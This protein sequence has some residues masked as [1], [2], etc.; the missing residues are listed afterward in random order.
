MIFSILHRL[1]H[2]ALNKKRLFL[3][4][5]CAAAACAIAIL[6]PATIENVTV[7]YPGTSYIPINQS[8]L[9]FQRNLENKIS[10]FTV[11]SNI[12]MTP[13]SSPAINVTP[14]ECLEQYSIND[15]QTHDL[16]GY[17]KTMRCWPESYVLYAPD[18]LRPGKN[19]IRMTLKNEH[20]PHGINLEGSLNNFAAFIV[21]CFAFMALAAAFWPLATHPLESW[22]RMVL[23]AS[24]ALTLI[25]L[26]CFKE[27]RFWRYALLP[28]AVALADGV[29]FGMTQYYH[30][31]QWMLSATNLMGRTLP[32]LLFVRFL[33]G[34]GGR[35]FRLRVSVLSMMLCLAF[36]T[37]MMVSIAAKEYQLYLYDGQ[38]YLELFAALCLEVAASVPMRELARRAYIHRRVTV[39]FLLSLLPYV[40]HW[41][42]LPIWQ[43]FRGITASFIMFFVELGG[44]AA[45][46]EDYHDAKWGIAVIIRTVL[47]ELEVI[48]DCA[49]YK[50]VMYFIA[51]F[52]AMLLSRPHRMVKPSKI[53]V[54][55]VTGL[56]GVMAIN[57]WRM[58]SLVLFASGL[59]ESCGRSPA[60]YHEISSLHNQGGPVLLFS[61]VIYLCLYFWA[62][63]RWLD[64]EPQKP[65]VTTEAS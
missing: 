23:F 61:Y 26:S 44:Y 62:C 4:A 65:I 21:A 2:T 11:E 34:A 31:S 19:N 13:L 29:L 59:I 32:L 45:R 3:C 50:T 24:R 22:Q 47:W 17:D 51:L 12:H 53:V 55:F 16:Q 10:T 39:L 60:V 37:L 8:E 54:A 58:A 64:H 14:D 30:L 6:G 48:R 42:S 38:V 25:P 18:E 15:Q 9:P 43:E 27:K 52:A 20:G 36:T 57:A 56:L 63:S 5:A 49:D 40:E 46:A 7:T 1:L 35:P 33:D 28:F 41:L